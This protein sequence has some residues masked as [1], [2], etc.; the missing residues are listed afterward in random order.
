VTVANSLEPAVKFCSPLVAL[1]FASV[2]LTAACGEGTMDGAGQSNGRTDTG[3]SAEASAA[4]Q[5][6]S[7]R[8]VEG[9][10]P[11][12]RADGSAAEL[13]QVT[14]TEHGD[15]DRIRF[16]FG[17]GVD[18]VF[19]E[20]L[21][22]LREPGR[23]QKVPLAGEHRL[24]LVFVGM[25]RQ[26]PAVDV[27]PTSAVRDVRVTGVFEGEMIAGIGTHTSGDGP[28]GFRI[29]LDGRT[30]TVDVAHKASTTSP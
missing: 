28:G 19:A 12:A 27:R 6:V 5:D 8:E 24:V 21:D 4:P 15:F 14:V 26:D 10:P 22:A 16:E 11:H 13:Q 25:A 17:G 18:K 20:Y 3:S 30:V 2:L 1:A 23:G 29:G 7:P 9:Q